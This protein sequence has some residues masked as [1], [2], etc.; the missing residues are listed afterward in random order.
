MII[1]ETSPNKKYLIGVLMILVNLGGRFLID[2]LSENQK[3]NLNNHITR[4]IIAFSLF[5]L[6]TRDLLISITLTI[7]YILFVSNLFEE[8]INKKIKKELYI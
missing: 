4:K 7:I 2:D 3:K 8:I 1:N 5:Y 6:A